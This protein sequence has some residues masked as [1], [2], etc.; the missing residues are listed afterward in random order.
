MN[1]GDITFSGDP[2]ECADTGFIG[3]L[4][5]SDAFHIGYRDLM[6]VSCYFSESQRTN[7]YG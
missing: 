3:G 4:E 1:H 5:H 6:L 7:L 2:N